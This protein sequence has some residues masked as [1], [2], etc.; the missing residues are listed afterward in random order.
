MI[1]RFSLLCMLS[2][3]MQITLISFGG[4]LLLFEEKKRRGA[5]FSG[6]WQSPLEINFPDVSLLAG[7]SSKG[8]EITSSIRL[9]N[10]SVS[11]VSN[12]HWDGSC[13]F[14]VEGGSNGEKAKN[15]FLPCT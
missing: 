5:L 14:K 15:T 10:P 6:S 2:K 3:H 12:S 9:L 4:Q 1:S 11:V 7:V 8:Q 13:G